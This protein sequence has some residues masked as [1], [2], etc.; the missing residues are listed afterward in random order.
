MVTLCVRPTI[1][2]VFGE[3][4]PKVGT[5]LS[6]GRLN[7]LDVPPPGAGVSGGD[8]RRPSDCGQDARI[9]GEI[10]FRRVLPVD[11]DTVRRSV[12][13]DGRRGKK[14]V[15]VRV[16]F[17]VTLPAN[18]GTEAETTVGTGYSTVSVNVLEVPP[19]PQ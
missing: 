17:C 1:K 13:E 11:G 8:G 10:E 5:A 12:D 18:E 15:P 4:V 16:T 9:E 7:T 19:P 3:I 6:I 2:A 14:P